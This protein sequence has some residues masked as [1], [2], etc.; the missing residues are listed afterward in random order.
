MEAES[1]NGSVRHHGPD[2]N[3]PPPVN[4]PLVAEIASALSPG[5]F[6][7]ALSRIQ[8]S[9]SRGATSPRPHAASGTNS[10]RQP[11]ESSPS[12][13]RSAKVPSAV[14]ERMRSSPRSEKTKSTPKPSRNRTESERKPKGGPCPR[15]TS[16]HQSLEQRSS[17]QPQPMSPRINSRQLAEPTSPR[18]SARGSP[19]LP[20]RTPSH[21]M[22]DAPYS[23]RGSKQQLSPRSTPRGTSTPG[24]PGAATALAVAVATVA[25]PSRQRSF[26]IPVATAV[27]YPLL[28]GAGRGISADQN[29]PAGKMAVPPLNLPGRSPTFDPVEQGLAGAKAVL[30]PRPV[31]RA[32]PQR[33]PMLSFES[34]LESNG[35]IRDLYDTLR[36]TD[37]LRDQL[38]PRQLSPRSAIRAAYAIA[39]ASPSVTPRS[40]PAPHA[41]GIPPTAGKPVPRRS[42][43]LFWEPPPE[44][45][46][47]CEQSRQAHDLTTKTPHLLS[48]RALQGGCVGHTPRSMCTG[49]S[50]EDTAGRAAEL[51]AC[52]SY[53]ARRRPHLR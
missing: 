36:E 5:R 7:Q 6:K 38:S 30:S 28:Q 35:P 26:A 21:Q 1:L 37:S 16:S 11:L 44:A 27:A 13:E 29:G 18:L 23:A 41:P 51:A 12:F 52:S 25:T 49:R 24:P 43:A 45:Q 47:A 42:P 53:V 8:G 4:V 20:P 48:P 17:P 22:S 14:L 34:M 39:P 40:V 3:G 19:P 15:T 31:A 33:S 9:S 46:V 32:L 50:S 2:E 10:P